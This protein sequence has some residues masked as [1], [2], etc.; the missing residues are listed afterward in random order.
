MSNDRCFV[1]IAALVLLTAVMPA[2]GSDGD[3][4]GG[5]A[6]SGSDSFSLD[7]NDFED[8]GRTWTVVMSGDQAFEAT[9]TAGGSDSRVTAP[10]TSDT[11][12]I[13][14]NGA[15]IDDETGVTSETVGVNFQL[16]PMDGQDAIIPGEYQASSAYISTSTGGATEG[17][18]VLDKTYLH[19][20]DTTGTDMTVTILEY[21][22]EGTAPNRRFE[23]KGTFSGTVESD[24]SGST[25][26]CDAGDMLTVD[27]AFKFSE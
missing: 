24:C 22:E 8:Y 10:L 17:S 21:V 14:V 3:G 11:I 27:G 4:G 18:S 20:S 16:E 2:C 5:S 19:G 26:T 7:P 23:A 25:H 13:G 6:G 1:A 9:A 12:T 15:V